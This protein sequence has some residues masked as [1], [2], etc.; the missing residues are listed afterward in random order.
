MGTS[1]YLLTIK[2]L[3]KMFFILSII[4]LPLCLVL[5]SGSVSDHMELN[6]Y[7]KLFA[8]SSIGNIQ[9]NHGYACGGVDIA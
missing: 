6:G 7:T 3:A 2:A 4:S 1:L 8:S 9:G 5:Q